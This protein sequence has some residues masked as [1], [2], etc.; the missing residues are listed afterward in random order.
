MIVLNLKTNDEQQ[1]ILKNYL[2]ENVSEDLAK[3]IN[4]GVQITKD[5][6]VVTKK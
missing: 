3:K 6:V 1:E 4:K 5:G 2:Q